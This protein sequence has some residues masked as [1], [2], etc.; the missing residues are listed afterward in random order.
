MKYLKLY[1][2]FIILFISGN[3]LSQDTLLLNNGKKILINSHKLIENDTY[4]AF[5]K[6]NGKIKEIDRYDVFSV[7]SSD[8]NEKIYFLPD[9]SGEQG[10][11]V[12]QMRDYV[13]GATAARENFKS[14]FATSIGFVTGAGLAI[15][16]PGSPFII[17]GGVTAS[18][19]TT[20]L[21][22]PRDK[23]IIKENP[24]YKD[25]EFFISGYRNAATNKRTR[26]G[27]FGA[28][29]GIAAGFITA[30]IIANN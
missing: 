12:P 13:L 16:L 26:N 23:R 5:E 19:V 29:T 27:I 8:G 21:I 18:S 22:V 2:L 20:G 3:I 10:L 9:N 4:I 6:L 30:T 15:T 11:S 7:N 24:E 25:N 14:P 28:L 1:T 17:G